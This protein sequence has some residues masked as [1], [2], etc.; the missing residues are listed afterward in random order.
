VAEL[1][2]HDE[3]DLILTIYEADFQAFGYGLDPNVADL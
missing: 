1:I 3:R 2:G